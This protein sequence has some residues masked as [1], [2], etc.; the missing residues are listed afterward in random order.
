MF[1]KN[2]KPLI[3]FVATIE[4]LEEFEEITPKPT[5][6]FIPQWF[7]D[8]PNNPDSIKMC[9]SFPDFFSQGYVIPAWQDILLQYDKKTM[10]W[11]IQSAGVF[12]EWGIH[13]N[14]QFLDFADVTTPVDKKEVS[15]IF[16]ANSPWSIVTPKGWSVLQLPMFYNFEH[17]FSVT[18]GIIDTDLYH[19]INM[20]VLFPADKNEI[21]IKRGTPLAMFIPFKRTKYKHVV[22]K[23][24]KK[25]KKVV[26]Q[27]H[28]YLESHFLGSG[29]YR[30][31]QRKRDKESE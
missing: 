28:L 24:N 4:G 10:N 19:E 26:S 22:R 17:E 13:H 12:F 21:F 7:K 11:N 1:K 30:K 29:A 20:Q 18:P 6:S 16:K 2:E 5:K 8:A 31:M 15:I 14:G 27:N 3:E 25:D 9:P 23:Q